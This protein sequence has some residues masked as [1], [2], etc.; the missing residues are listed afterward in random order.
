MPHG[1]YM[2]HQAHYL[3]GKCIELYVKCLLIKSDAK[4]TEGG[5]MTNAMESY[6]LRSSC[7]KAQ[8]M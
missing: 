4:V 2:D 8:S 3:E 6:G 5:K 7:Q 1:F